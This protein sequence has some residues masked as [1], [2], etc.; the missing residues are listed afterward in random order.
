MK[1][2]VL[3]GSGSIGSEI[4]KQLL[5]DGFE[6][7]VQYYRTDINELTSK[8][9]D[10]KV[11]FIQADLSQ[12]IDIDKTFGDIKSL[13]CLIYASGQSLYG[14]LQDMKDH[15]IDACYQLNVLQL[16]RL[17]R[18]FVDVLRQ[19]DNGRII[20]ISSIW[21]ETGASMETIYSTMKSAQLGFVKALSQEF[22]L[23]SVTVNAIAPGFVAGNMASEWQEDE[24]QAMITELP[25]QRL[26]LP[27]EVAHT[28]AYLYH[29]N[30][31]SVT[32]TIQKVNGAWYI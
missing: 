14:V 29:P 19:S 23:T 10:D 8:F 30:A 2:L 11:H 15:D 6:V 22:A 21:G 28:C 16:I 18:Y 20:V 7:Y 17:C 9:N 24:L 27:S 13:D 26:V 4:V 1:A 32:G 12:T 5:T 3:G 25:Q 31:R